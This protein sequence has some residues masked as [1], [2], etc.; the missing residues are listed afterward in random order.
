MLIEFASYDLL[1]AVGW[2]THFAWK[3][4][5]TGEVSHGHKLGHNGLASLG[6]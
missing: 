6:H 3:K 2:T 4:V 1:V 5:E